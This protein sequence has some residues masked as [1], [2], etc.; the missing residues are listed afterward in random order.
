MVTKL[1]ML[2]KVGERRV[3]KHCA[4]PKCKRERTLVR[5]PPNFK[6]ADVICDFCG[7]LAQVKTVTVKSIDRAPT[8]ILGAA[9]Q[10]QRERMDAGI[11]FPLFIVGVV[12]ER[13]FAIYY[14]AA[15]LQTP[16]MFVPR[17]PL[18]SKAKRAGGQG[19]LIDLTAVS[20]RLVRLK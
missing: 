17:R 12:S 1:Q 7:Y 2:G 13:K 18:S 14:L 15:D 11:Y 5:L 10:P 4:C 20:D 9:W 16:A 3:V 19:Y 6:C 8:Q